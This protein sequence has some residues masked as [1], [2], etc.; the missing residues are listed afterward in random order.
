M[1]LCLLSVGLSKAPVASSCGIPPGA[2]VP[3]APATLGSK[4]TVCRLGSLAFVLVGA[5]YKSSVLALGFDGV[6]CGPGVDCCW[7]G[8]MK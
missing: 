7:D 1:K 4:A 5:E 2:M 6:R 3:G 8:G